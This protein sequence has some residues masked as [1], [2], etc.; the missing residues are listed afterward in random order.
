MKDSSLTRVLFIDKNHVSS[1]I[2]SAF[3]NRHA[4]AGVVS[5][6]AGT[7]PKPLPETLPPLFAEWGFPAPDPRAVALDQTPDL[8]CGLTI[9]ISFSARDTAETLP[10][11]LFP[12]FWNIPEIRS[13][14]IETLRL[15][16]EELEKAVRHFVNHGYHDAIARRTGFFENIFE[17]LD[18]GILVH[19]LSRRIFFF[20]RGAE[21][22]TGTQKKSVVGRDCH[23]VFAPRLCENSCVFCESGGHPDFK[24]STY[25]AIFTGGGI[26]KELRITRVPL[27]NE[28]GGVAGAVLAFSDHTRLRELEEKLGYANSFSGIIGSDYKMLAV[29]QLIRDI[30]SADFP[31]VITGESGTGK[32]LVAAAIHHES[33]RRD[34]PFLAVNCGA[35]PEGILESELFGHVRGAFSGAIRDKKGRFELADHGTLFLDEIGELAPRMQVKLLRVLQDGI[36]EPVG[37]ETP[38][39]VNVR[40]ICATNRNLKTLVSEGDF[41]DDLYYR[42]AVVPVELPP[43]R[44]RRND[45][46]L[47][48]DHF[49][50]HY[51]GKL[52]REPP[53]FSDESMSL[54][55][56]YRWPGN[57]RELQNAIQFAL[58]KCREGQIRPAHLPPELTETVILSNPGQKEKGRAG[59]HPKLSAEAVREALARTDGNK[60]KAARILG[61]GRA[62]L[63]NFMREHGESIKEES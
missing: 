1:R 55:M 56:T 38:K 45:I 30:A 24:K 16:G 3:F 63:Y 34:K 27:R 42:L 21:K 5:S 10:P 17:S 28:N 41:R 8:L 53:D 57:V 11:G 31:V 47:L 51:A 54:F 7:A 22:I 26:R 35:L 25:Y 33:N 50:R 9:A 4:P 12:V 43:L 52:N 13:L 15:H 36:F 61:V 6:S 14:D 59:R 32:E 39:K 23:E 44:D 62:T 2:A 19:D 58:V 18:E 49:V 20:S 40:V 37:S 60:A 48:A 29:Y 46:P